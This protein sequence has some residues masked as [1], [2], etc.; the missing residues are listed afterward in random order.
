MPDSLDPLAPFSTRFL[1]GVALV[2]CGTAIRI[3]AYHALGT[4]F[5]YE[6]VVK[7]NHRLVTTGPYQYVRHP[8]YTGVA[9]LLLGTHLVHFGDGGYVTYCNID[10]TPMILFVNIWRYGALY[11]VFALCRRCRIED[12]QLHDR[13]GEEWEKYRQEVRYALVP[14]VY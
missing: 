14:L 5:T 12:G 9:L 4:L 13:F 2:F 7:D 8:S 10:A 6:V 3:S 11:T 1:V